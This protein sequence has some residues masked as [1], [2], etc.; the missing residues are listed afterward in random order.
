MS[1]LFFINTNYTASSVLLPHQFGGEP[2]GSQ[3]LLQFHAKLIT[4]F[5]S[6]RG[7]PRLVVFMGAARD[8]PHRH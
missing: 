8:L 1:P 4:S 3:P 6:W 7:E 2:V 5:P